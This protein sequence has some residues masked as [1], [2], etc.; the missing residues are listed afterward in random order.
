MLV[1]AI[2]I[3]VVSEKLQTFYARG[4]HKTCRFGLPK[5]VAHNKEYSCFIKV[6]RTYVH[7][8]KYN[9]SHFKYVVNILQ[10]LRPTSAN[11]PSGTDCCCRWNLYVLVQH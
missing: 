3:G 9:L 10:Y 2:R 1:D 11:V 5:K 8:S 4:N 7:T 6:S